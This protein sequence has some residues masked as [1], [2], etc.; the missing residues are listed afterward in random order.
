[1]P[2]ATAICAILNN[3]ARQS[4]HVRQRATTVAHQPQGVCPGDIIRLVKE[5][6]HCDL[7]VHRAV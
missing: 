3:N 2:K 4:Q 5:G 7:L 6:D 1:M